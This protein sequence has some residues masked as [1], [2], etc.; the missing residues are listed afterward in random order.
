MIGDLKKVLPGKVAW[1]LELF[2][3][4]S[5][6]FSWH[7]KLLEEQKDLEILLMATRKPTL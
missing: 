1:A 4:T 6:A 7:Q 5:L 3:L 2:Y